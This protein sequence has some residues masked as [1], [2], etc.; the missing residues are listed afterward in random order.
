MN[1]LPINLDELVDKAAANG[2]YASVTYSLQS[3]ASKPVVGEIPIKYYLTN[4]DG[5]STEYPTL[6]DLIDAIPTS[7]SAE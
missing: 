2:C 5:N 6:D 1:T 7:K 3:E 4:A